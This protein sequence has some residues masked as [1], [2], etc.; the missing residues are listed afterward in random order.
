MCVTYSSKLYI[1]QKRIPDDVIQWKHFPRYWPFVRGIHR[2]P[3]NSPHKG[4]WRGA[5][6]GFFFICG[7]INTWVNNREAG[8]LR[9]HR[10]HYDVIVVCK[11]DLGKQKYHPSHGLF[12][13]LNAIDGWHKQIFLGVCSPPN[14]MLDYCLIYLTNSLL[15]YLVFMEI[16]QDPR[17]ISMFEH[18]VLL[19]RINQ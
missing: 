5:L 14:L 10:V 4:Q 9:R 7:W 3:V 18:R 12:K 8:D 1:I 13:E 19:M 11:I 15:K 6:M 16:I 17:V 2:S